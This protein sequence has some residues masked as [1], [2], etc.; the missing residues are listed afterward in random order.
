MPRQYVPP[1][2]NEKYSDIFW[3]SLYGTLCGFGFTEVRLVW[4]RTSAFLVAHAAFVGLIGPG[5]ATYPPGLVMLFAF[6]GL[7][8]AGLWMAMNS[9]GWMNQNLWYWYAAR[10]RFKDVRLPTDV[11]GTELVPKPNDPIFWV[12]QMRR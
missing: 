2:G 1:Y 12:A 3:A 8:L 7:V 10:L 5:I 11:F 9:L 4:M 6:A